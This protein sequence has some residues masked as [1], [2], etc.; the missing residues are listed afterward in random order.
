L[1]AR[2]PTPE[3]WPEIEQA[4]E[5]RFWDGYALATHTDRREL[6]AVYLFGYV[7]EMLLKTAF[8]RVHGTPPYSDIGRDRRGARTGVGYR[9]RNDHDLSY[10]MHVLER[11][12]V[13]AGR[14]LDAALVGA[15]ALNIAV[16]SVHW[17]ESLRYR[18]V[19]PAEQEVRELVSAVE[20]IRDHYSRLW[21]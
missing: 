16:A 18:A 12:R 3:T 1:L 20:W 5:E 8:Y 17:R 19:V 13:V 10:W 14:P 7:I 4:A 2:L 6:G 9:P 11:A 15:M 21:S